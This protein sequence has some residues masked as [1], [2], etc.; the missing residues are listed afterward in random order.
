MSE[1]VEI[2]PIPA[3][4]AWTANEFRARD[5]WIYEL[6]A[7]DRECLDRG[8]KHLKDRCKTIP[9][10]A[11]DFPVGEFRARIDA[12]REELEHGSGV[13]L[14]RGLE[15]DRYSLDEVRQ[16]YWGFGAHMGRGLAQTP[17][18]SLLV[19]VLDTGGNIL[20]DARAR[21]YHTNEKL[22]FHND[23]G[24]VVGLLCYR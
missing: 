2:K 4:V 21:A 19:D 14:V 11:E 6:S 24:D 22:A 8:L 1:H 7:G 5:R 3:P 18:G 15:V 12:I 13:L 23:Q 20:K 9:F 17:R 10:G 16:I